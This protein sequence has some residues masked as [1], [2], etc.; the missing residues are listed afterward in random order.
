MT[1]QSNIPDNWRFFGLSARER[2][3]TNG[4]AALPQ[5]GWPI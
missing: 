1:C 2:L 5:N 3:I 4:A